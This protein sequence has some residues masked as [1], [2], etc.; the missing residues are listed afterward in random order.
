[1]FDISDKNARYELAHRSLGR[2]QSTIEGLIERLS[3]EYGEKSDRV[4]Y[5][6]HFKKSVMEVEYMIFEGILAKLDKTALYELTKL[7]NEPR[8]STRWD[9]F[10]NIH[11]PNFEHIATDEIVRLVSDFKNLMITEKARLAETEVERK[12]RELQYEIANPVHFIFASNE[13]KAKLIEGAGFVVAG[14]VIFIIYALIKNV[15]IIE[16][17]K[18]AGGFWFGLTIVPF[19]IRKTITKMKVKRLAGDVDKIREFYHSE[20]IES[21]YYTG[22]L[23]AGIPMILIIIFIIW[24]FG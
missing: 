15:T 14:S 11:V 19:I 2:L 23:V 4:N 5:P 24:I 9:N 13:A 20:L 17:L 18:F 8:G 3:T 12:R 6:D 22:A 7:A 21:S 16:A 10:W 1:M